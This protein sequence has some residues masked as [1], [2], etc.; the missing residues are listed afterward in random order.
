MRFLR[1]HFSI[2]TEANVH[3]PTHTRTH[4][5]FCSSSTR[6]YL[7]IE[8]ISRPLERCSRVVCSGTCTYSYNCF[9]CSAQLLPFRS[10]TFSPLN[11]MH[12]LVHPSICARN[13]IQS[14]PY[15]KHPSVQSSFINS[16]N[17]LFI[18]NEFTILAR[19]CIY[20]FAVLC[21]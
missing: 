10:T 15:N 13:V 1:L 4:L 19:I 21:S 9:V 8:R 20:L 17:N 5:I 3:T 7:D 14:L 2:Q 11:V 12:S 6:L 16:L 18:L